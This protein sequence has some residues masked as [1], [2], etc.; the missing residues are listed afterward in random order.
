MIGN[1]GSMIWS[2]VGPAEVHDVECRL[3]DPVEQGVEID[4]PP[5]L[6]VRTTS[7][8]EVGRYAASDLSSSSPITNPHLRP[9][10]PPPP[11]LLVMA[12]LTEASVGY[13]YIYASANLSSADSDLRTVSEHTK[14]P[15]DTNDAR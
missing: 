13:A 15:L 9:P 1:R 12:A 8:L 2:G 5:P 4:Q 14:L 6:V 11:P 3:T 7:P 10:P